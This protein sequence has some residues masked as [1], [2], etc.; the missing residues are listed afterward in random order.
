MGFGGP[1][2]TGRG[3]GCGSVF[4][5]VV[6]FI[7]L[8]AFLTIVAGSFDSGDITKSTIERTPLDK[9]L[10][11]ETAY[12]KD[13]LDWIN[14]SSTLERGMKEFYNKTGVQPFLYITD[15]ISGNYTPSNEEFDNFAHK[16]YDDHF[17][18]EAH[19][20]VIFKEYNSQYKMWY[21]AG[22]AA[23]S[24]MDSEA[25]EILFDYIEKQ[26]FSDLTDEEMFSKAFSLAADRIMYKKVSP[27]PYIISFI[28]IVIVVVVVFNFY[29]SNK[30]KKEKEAK[31]ME[32][33]LKK[34]L[35]TFGESEL[36]DLEDK[37]KEDK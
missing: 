27:W 17:T 12:F 16:F 28:I 3:Y 33:M 11:N 18:D 20:L 1:K 4:V 29:K 36:D 13:D 25:V 7:I 2:V 26:Y 9:S 31:E 10:V 24:V 8:I 14:S 19:I 23:K 21:V 15:N 32:E 35:E 37:Y 22:S 30:A 6:A 34:P 5:I